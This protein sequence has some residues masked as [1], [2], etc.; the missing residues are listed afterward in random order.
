MDMESLTDDILFRI[1]DILPFKIDTRFRQLSKLAITRRRSLELDKSMMEHIVCRP[2]DQLLDTCA[3]Y[4]ERIKIYEECNVQMLR[5]L[6]ENT[7]PSL[8]HLDSPGSTS[9]SAMND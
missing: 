8:V 7:Y 4:V 1:I 3:L 2:F 5:V 9:E 6:V